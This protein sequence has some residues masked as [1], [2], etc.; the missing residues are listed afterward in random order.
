MA[1]ILSDSTVVDSITL[2][3]EKFFLTKS[4]SGKIAIF[5]LGKKIPD[6]PAKPCTYGT[7]F[8]I[9]TCGQIFF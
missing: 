4:I 1:V 6:L 7:E 5:A 3:T 2:Y 9:Y 8:P